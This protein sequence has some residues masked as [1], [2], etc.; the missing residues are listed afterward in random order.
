L[1]KDSNVHK[2][3]NAENCIALRLRLLTY[4]ARCPWQMS[5]PTNGLR[6]NKRLADATKV[7]S[8]CILCVPLLCPVNAVIGWRLLMFRTS[9]LLGS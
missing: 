1:F 8:T 6:T 2:G 3:M 4:P 9:F 5:N 7:D